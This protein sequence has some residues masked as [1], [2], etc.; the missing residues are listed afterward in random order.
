MK[1]IN[2]SIIVRKAL[3]SCGIT[4]IVKDKYPEVHIEV[5]AGLDK[6]RSGS[7]EN[8]QVIFL[9]PSLL[10]SPKQVCLEKFY[11][12]IENSKLIAV[13]PSTPVDELLPYFDAVITY[14][15]SMDSVVEILNRIVDKDVA[16]LPE[17]SKDI[18]SER[19][20]DVLRGV[21]LGLTNKDISDTLHISTHTVITHRKNIT[22]KLGI[23]TI[24]GLAVYAV[25]NGLV[26]PEEIEDF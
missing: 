2:I 19:E 4:H 14:D 22:A 9:D 13:F 8:D 16:A 7:K 18:I 17:T 5:Y 1:K 6:F 23:K 20:K 15:L 3:I 24:A 11:K 10:E 12:R 26:S 21:A 25:L